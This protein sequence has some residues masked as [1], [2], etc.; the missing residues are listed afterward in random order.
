MNTR[1][2][3]Y[4]QCDIVA[5][6]VEGSRMLLGRVPP[7]VSFA[8]PFL[9]GAFALLLFLSRGGLP[10]ADPAR[11]SHTGGMDAMSI[12]MNPGATPA[13]SNTSIGSREKCARINEN[14]T[15]DADEDVAEIT[16]IFGNVASAASNSVTDTDQN[17]DPGSLVGNKVRITSGTALN[18]VRTITANTATT[19]TVG[20]N[21]SATPAQG[22][23]FEVIAD[24]VLQ[25]DVT[26]TNIPALD[27]RMLGFAYTLAYSAGNIKVEAKSHAFKL[28]ANP[29][30]SLTDAADTVP[31]AN[32]TW[33]GGALDTAGT[34]GSSES[35]S[36][37]LER[38]SIASTETAVNGVYTL[39]LSG[40]VHLRYL[41]SAAFAADTVNNASV[42]VNENCPAQADVKLISQTVTFPGQISVDQDVQMTIDKVLHNNGPDDP[43]DIDITKTITV[44][45]DCTVNGQG[46]P[47]V[48]INDSETGVAI[49]SS[50]TVPYQELDTINCSQP[51]AHQITV[52]NCI[53]IAGGTDPNSANN[54]DTD[55]VNFTVQGEANVL[56]QSI[57][58][59]APGSA[60]TSVPFDVTV[61]ATV[62]N[63]GPFGPVNADAT[64]DLTVPAGCGRSP[65]NT[66]GANNLSL[67]INT[68]VSVQRTWSV[69]CTETGP[70]GFTGSA[71]VSVD[72]T[73]VV[74]PD[75]NN[76]AQGQ[77]T[78]NVAVGGA[79]VKVTSVTVG[80]PPTAP[81][82]TNF[83]VTVNTTVHNNGPTAP[84]NTDI[85]LTLNLPNDCFTPVTSITFNNASLG[86]SIAAQLPQLTFYVACVDHSAHGI[87]ATAVIAIDD[88]SAGDPNTSNNTLTSASSTTAVIR[89]ADLKV[90]GASVTAP[91]SAVTS[92]PFNVT[93]DASIHNN[94]PDPAPA[95]V[96]VTLA[97]PGDCSAPNNPRVVN[98]SLPVSNA[99]PLPTQT[100]AVTC[101]DRSFHDFSA[102]VGIAGPLHVSDPN[103]TNN[104]AA[105]PGS[106]TVPVYDVSDV[107][108]N[109]VNIS[110]PGQALLNTAFNVTATTNTRNAGPNGPANAD[111]TAT[112]SLPPDCS[113]PDANPRTV[114]DVA[115]SVSVVTPV[116]VTW[117]VTCT[118]QSD[119]TFSASSSIVLDQ[120]HVSDPDISN[121]SGQSTD[122]V[123]PV[124]AQADGKIVSATIL[125]PPTTI[126]ADTN[127]NITVRKVLHN[128]GSFGPATFNLSHA[129]NAPDGCTVTS[130]ALSSHSL[131]T[132]TPI[133]IDEV[134]VINCAAGGPYTFQFNNSLTVTGLHIVDPVFGNNLS[135]AT[136]TVRVDT[137]GDGVPDATENACGS[138]ANNSN[139]IPERIDGV[140]DNVDDDGND[141]AD[142]PLPLTAAGFD[143]DGD[144]YIGTTEAHVFTPATDRDQ[145]PC[146]GDAWAVDLVGGFFSTNK[147]NISDLASFISPVR[148]LNTSPSDAGFNQR[149]DLVPGSTFGKQ[150]NVQ[151]MGSLVTA[152]PP[153]LGGT[154]AYNGPD[155][156][157]PP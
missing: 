101:T 79:D 56:V 64:V 88:P 68:N 151:D 105:S 34:A 32:G 20:S 35:G 33:T 41:D 95:E 140:F 10:E 124:V 74:D 113:T 78:T 24:D 42:A 43:V 112:L 28:G 129:S 143:C 61:D 38:L 60:L 85:T 48:L 132:S 119:H 27:Q 8:L 121:G 135:T 71:S 142:E 2:T 92:S 23:T 107:R 59:T 154:R 63:N 6:T 77:A 7:R 84:V 86:P 111:L 62:R 30:S 90:N 131:A 102:T 26:A 117:S 73:H 12:D 22:D 21:W 118:D 87:T 122:I 72:Q 55:V 115:L 136:L 37:I 93:V 18:D 99:T 126:A 29:G 1:L 96:T 69:T 141:G 91:S 145:D 31:D 53:D 114:Q 137:D 80:S 9:V 58:V 97:M 52:E 130:P 51:S 150:I 46:G 133:T 45:D 128:N 148:R 4:G 83:P 76:S 14:D 116:G 106:S 89:T 152:R 15:L 144:G 138:N 109:S 40:A 16:T 127:V 39:T 81:I 75:S 98:I 3:D 50:T 70:A 153:M 139:S 13:N 110:G 66:Q 108:V 134:W 54:C 44:P 57:T 125:S 120:F 149:W 147:A 155:C 19:I 5:A 47:T 11:A 146:G 17:L 65:N 123:I 156:P 25:F 49:N 67:L 36:G 104:S 94:G 157:W 103:N 82:S 100:F